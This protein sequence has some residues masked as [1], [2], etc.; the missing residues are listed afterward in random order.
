MINGTTPAHSTQPQKNLFSAISSAAFSS[1]SLLLLGLTCTAYIYYGEKGPMSL[2]KT[3]ASAFFG[4]PAL[5]GG[6]LMIAWGIVIHY[7]MVFLIVSLLF[8][9]YPRIL[10]TT[11]NKFIVVAMYGIISWCIAGLLINFIEAHGPSF[12]LAQLPWGLHLVL[13][14]VALGAPVSYLSNKF[15]MSRKK[16]KKNEPPTS[17]HEQQVFLE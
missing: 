2:L 9:A 1:G 15:Y 11:R 3:I 17:T 16:T 13:H 14:L 8:P 6:F 7:F 5:T 10:A 4:T 12:I